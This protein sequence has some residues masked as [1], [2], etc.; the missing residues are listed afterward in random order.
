VSATGSG[1]KEEGLDGRGAAEIKWMRLDEIGCGD[2]FRTDLS[3]YQA[4]SG[5][6]RG[7][8]RNFGRLER[9]PYPALLSSIA[10]PQEL[11]RFC[12]LQQ[13]NMRPPFA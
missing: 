5:Q 2:A 1:G 13:H 3:D 8:R 12:R 6:C 9:Q 7:R 11:Q 4:L 10:S